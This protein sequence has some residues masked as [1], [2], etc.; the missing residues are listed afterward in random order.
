MTSRKTHFLS[1]LV[2]KVSLISSQSLDSMNKSRK[3]SSRIYEEAKLKL[4]DKLRKNRL[5]NNSGTNTQLVDTDGMNRSRSHQMVDHNRGNVDQFQPKEKEELRLPRFQKPLNNFQNQLSLKYK[6][7]QSLSNK[8]R[9]QNNDF[10]SVESHE[11]SQNKKLRQA[12]FE[13]K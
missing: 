3:E 2:L 4:R 7:I 11:S 13:L 10:R 1:T 8:K 9:E 5:Q 12:H 6:N